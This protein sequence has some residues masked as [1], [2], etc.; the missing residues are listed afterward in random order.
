MF[1]WANAPGDDNDSY[2]LLN[3]DNMKF[4]NEEDRIG[5]IRK[6]YGIMSS[7]LILTA[8]VTLLP[9]LS[10]GIRTTMISNPGVGL[11]SAI[12]AMVLACSLFCSE[13]LARQ[14]PANYILMF[15]FTLCEAYS[16]AFICAVLDSNGLIVV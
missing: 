2:R 16:V 8:F 7:Q 10:Y 13:S 1:R 11:A 5:F 14:V 6:V 12:M 15:F 9:Y 4:A 3:D